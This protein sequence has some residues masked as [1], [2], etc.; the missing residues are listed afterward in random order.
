MGGGYEYPDSAHRLLEKI[1]DNT[2]GITTPAGGGP[3][4]FAG[5][6]YGPEI[7]SAQISHPSV[8]TVGGVNVL[9]LAGNANR[10]G[11]LIQNSGGQSC[12]ITLANAGSANGL[13]LLPGGI[14][15]WNDAKLSYGGPVYAR[16][17]GVATTLQVMEI[18]K[19]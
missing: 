15:E 17:N 19:S 13:V 10:R 2:A 9:V 16:W 12:F 4:S 8:V 5:V 1:A 18:N 7:G 11:F 14:F 6:T 3:S